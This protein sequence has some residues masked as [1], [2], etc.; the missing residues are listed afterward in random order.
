MSEGVVARLK[1]SKWFRDISDSC[2]IT[3]ESDISQDFKAGK[4]MKNIKY[5]DFQNLISKRLLQDIT[6]PFQ[7]FSEEIKKILVTSLL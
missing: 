4:V 2:G 3:Q 5:S 6:N 1:M 7:N